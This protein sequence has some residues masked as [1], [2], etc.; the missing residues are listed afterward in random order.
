M[1]VIYLPNTYVNVAGTNA[2]DQIFSIADPVLANF[3]G[4]QNLFGGL[5]NDFYFISSTGG[6]D[7]I[8][9]MFGEGTD[10]AVL[11]TGF[12]G[13]YTLTS[14]VENLIVRRFQPSGVAAATAA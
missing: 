3:G 4:L 2:D 14:N 6:N 11:F 9:E 10:T 8:F 7:V 5:G 12:T 13:A 1:A